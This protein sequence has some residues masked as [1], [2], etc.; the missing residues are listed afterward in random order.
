MVSPLLLTLSIPLIIRSGLLLRSLSH[1]KVTQ[2]HGVPDTAK[3]FTFESWVKYW[4]T[5]IGA[6]PL[7]SV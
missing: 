1:A 5:R 2:S 7:V 6:L 4:R 3:I